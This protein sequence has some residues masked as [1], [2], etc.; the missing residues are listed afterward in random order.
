MIAK[1]MASSSW[2]TRVHL[3]L[4]PIISTMG[5]HNG[6]MVQGISKRLVYI[7]IWALLMPISLYMMSD[8]DVMAWYGSPDA[9]Y[10]VGIH[11]HALFFL[12]ICL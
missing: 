10:S 3:R 1:Q 2:D 12:S 11:S 9:K 8:I 6:L 4:V 5:L 7:A